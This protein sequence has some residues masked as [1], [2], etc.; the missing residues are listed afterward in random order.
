MLEQFSSPLDEPM[1]KA[2]SYLLN[3]QLPDGHWEDYEL[4]VGSTDAWVTGYAGFALGEAAKHMTEPGIARKA[5]KGAYEAAD[6]LC[7]NRVATAG[8][9]FNS[10]TEPDADTTAWVG[11]LLNYLGRSLEEQDCQFLLSRKQAN[12]GFATYDKP[13][14]WGMSHPDVTPTVFL[15]LPARYQALVQEA[16]ITYV[17]NVRS[18]DGTWPSYWWRNSYYS[19]FINVEFCV[20]MGLMD[21]SSLSALV[22]KSLS[23]P[24]ESAFDLAC[25]VALAAISQFSAEGNI[26]LL[27]ILCVLQEANGKWHGG[28]NLRVTDPECAE[29]WIQPQGKLYLDHHG[30]ITTATALRALSFSTD[31][32]RSPK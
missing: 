19:T 24:I 6:W 20:A 5:L 32:L 15:A 14:S 31:I 22:T 29:P 26:E 3:C 21:L 13:K 27:N 4:P 1:T 2:V 23:N 11:R 12:G 30:L 9:G 8:W 18:I 10:T 17:T 28:W 16:T 25:L 7:R